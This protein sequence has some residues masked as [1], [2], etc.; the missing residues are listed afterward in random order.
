MLSPVRGFARA[1]VPG[2]CSG[3]RRLRR[4]FLQH[5]QA[6]AQGLAHGVGLVRIP[7]IFRAAFRDLAHGVLDGGQIQTEGLGGLPF[8][9]CAKRNGRRYRA[10]AGTAQRAG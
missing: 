9:H 2:A 3:L 6:L 7:G 10:L 8:A 4:R 1:K 5:G